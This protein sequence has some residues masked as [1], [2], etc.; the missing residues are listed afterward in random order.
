VSPARPARLAEILCVIALLGGIIALRFVHA[1]ADPLENLDWGFISDNGTWWKNPRLHAVWGVWSY[2]DANFGLLTGPTYTLAMRAIFA[3]FGVGFAQA[4]ATNAISGVITSLLVYVVVRREAGPLAALLAMAL[5][6]VNVIAVSYDRSSYPE[7]FQTMAM[8]ATVVAILASARRPW[9][10]VLGGVCVIITLLAKPPGLVLAPVATATWA[11]VW[12]MQR[13]QAPTAPFAW[14]APLLYTGTA[15]GVLAVVI[16][17]FLIPHL[18]DVRLHFAQQMRDGAELGALQ[19]ERLQLFGS[20]L[21]FRMNGFFRHEWHLFIPVA[22]FAAARMAR[23]ARTPVTTIELAAWIWLVLGLGVMGL[24]TYQNDR[25]FVFLVPPLAVLTAVAA[26]SAFA[27]DESRW[28]D[29]RLRRIG[30]GMGAGLLTFVLAFYL[31]PYGL[32]RVA[33]WKARMGVA[34]TPGFTGGLLLS[35]LATLVGVL[36]AWRQPSLRWRGSLPVQLV[37]VT[38]PM[39]YMGAKLGR[40]VQQSEYGLQHVSDALARISRGWPY[41]ERFALGWPATTLTMG[42]TVLSLNHEVKGLPPAQR[43][44]PQLELYA[45]VVGAKLRQRPEWEVPGRPRKVECASM[46]IWDGRYI[47]HIF[48][49]PARLAACQLAARPPTHTS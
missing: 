20:R 8:M 32:A 16:V 35:A 17:A 25:R 11:A 49:E 43:F 31:A 45:V 14:K 1:G 15:A 46:P 41:E 18:E 44:R 36:V 48:V 7:S 42:S 2:D 47:V 26:A 37:L 12:I 30:L 5:V 24:Q 9:V 13:R 21:G 27:L 4:F 22:A 38:L 33:A 40:R 3:L 10:A 19:I 6:G 28:R 39:L 23:I 29:V 34:W